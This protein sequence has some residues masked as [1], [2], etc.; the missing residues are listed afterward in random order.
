MKTRIISAC[1]MLPLLLLVYFGG[2]PLALA[3]LAIGLI[4]AHEFVKGYEELDVHANYGLVAVCTLALYALGLAGRFGG[5]QVQSLYAF[6]LFLVVILSL[7]TLFCPKHEKLED[8]M[9]TMLSCF[10]IV[11]F[12]YHVF[13]VDGISEYRLLIWLIFITAFG[14]DIFAYFTGYAI[15]KHKLCPTISPKKTIEGAVGGALGSVILCAIFAVA[16]VP[17]LLPHCIAIGVLGGVLSQFGDLTA[18]IFKR[19]MGIKDYGKLIPGHGGIMDR[20]DSILF[21]APLVYYYITFI[22]L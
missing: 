22:L 14:T 17:S 9:V 18:S 7:L 6:W 5:A 11:F 21:T 20:F 19:K 13:L 16:L 10:Y 3:C 15:G 2:I 12:S 8:A 1:I 4:G